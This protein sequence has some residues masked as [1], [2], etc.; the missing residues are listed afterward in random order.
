MEYLYLFQK[1]YLDG[2]KASSCANNQYNP[3]RI[4][5]KYLSKHKKR[6]RQ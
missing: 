6:I 2:N 3:L 4:T 5:F 1:E